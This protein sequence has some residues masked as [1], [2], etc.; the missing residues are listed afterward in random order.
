MGLPGLVLFAILFLW[1]LPHFFAIGWRHR[2]DY[3]RAG[4]RILPVVDPTGKS[5][6]RQTL[7]WTGI[8]LPISLL[9]SVIGTAGFI[10]AV[11]AFGLTLFFLAASL[12][13]AKET[14]DA[15]AKA[16]FLTSIAWLPAV[17]LLLVLDRV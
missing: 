8:L 10:Y 14:T 5:T 4:V 6:A 11:G 15:R 12:R 17:L 2:A 1:Q 3:A 13:F 7:I 16:L 9:P